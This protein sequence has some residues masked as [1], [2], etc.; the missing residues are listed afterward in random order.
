MRVYIGA[1]HAGFSLK[2][3]LKRF[4]PEAVDLSPELV[5][6]DDYPDVAA[7]VVEKVVRSRGRGI[8]ICG[9]GV[10]MCMAA[11][12]VSG[13]RAALCF[14][15]SEARGARREDDVNVLCLPG[16]LMSSR[17]A[18]EVVDAFLSTRFAGK[19]KGGRRFKRRLEKLRRLDER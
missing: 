3:K 14:E 8:L 15:A 1:D 12:K 6:G 5:P 17:N 13:G 9:S 19:E 7:E 2:E 16:R 11:N 10:G 4:Y 18:H